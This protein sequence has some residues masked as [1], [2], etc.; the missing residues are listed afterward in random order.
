L[1]CKDGCRQIPNAAKLTEPKR[2]RQSLNL[3]NERSRKW[4]LQSHARGSDGNFAFRH[5]RINAGINP[6]GLTTDQR[7]VGFARVNG[8]WIDIGAFESKLPP[9]VRKVT[10]N[11]GAAQRSN[12]TSVTV[13]FDAVVAFNGSAD[14]AFSL[15]RQSDNAMPLLSAAVAN[16][17]VTSVTLTFLTGPAVDFGSLADGRYTLTINQSQVSANGAQLDGNVD[18]TG[19]DDYV[20]TSS[21]TSGVYRLSGDADGNGSVTAAD[22]NAFRLA[23]GSVGSSIFD[24]NGDDQVSASDFNEFRTRYGITLVP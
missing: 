10:V 9:T 14:A 11:G 8:G 12:V 6:A 15:K 2:R 24:F 4:T 17:I 18:G 19:G 1:F 20:L 16:G 5:D 13:D 22:F 7:G 21:G 3:F 23:Y